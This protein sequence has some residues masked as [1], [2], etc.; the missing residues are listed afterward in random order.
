LC[1]DGIELARQTGREQVESLCLMV[2]AELDAYRGNAGKARADIPAL[3]ST[4]TTVG[5]SGA[6][7]RLTRALASLELS[8]GDADAAR[9]LTAALLADATELDEILGQLAG[10]VGIEA[11]LGTGDI[12]EA[13]RLLTLLDERANESDTGLRSL[14]DRCRGLLLA[15]HGEHVRA[16]DAL[17]RAAI[18]PELPQ[19]ADPLER[20]RT[21]L[22]LGTVQRRAQRKRDARDTLEAAV[23]RFEGLGARSWAARARAELRRIGGRSVARSELSETE[24]QIVRLVVAGYRNREVAAELSISPNTVAWNLSRIYRKVGVSSRT[25][26]AA[27]VASHASE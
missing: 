13:E 18:E 26:L 24:Q 10:S 3:L 14:A 19:L 27:R 5:Y 20:A 8:S 11:L 22:V 15:A 16:I 6:I 1:E 23:E 12:A 4:A 21:L 9:R 25:E 7:H 17:T 2:L